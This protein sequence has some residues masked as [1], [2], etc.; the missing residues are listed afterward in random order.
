M[1]VDRE[2]MKSL[3]EA[4]SSDHGHFM[5]VFLSTSSKENWREV[6]TT[7]LNSAFTELMKN[8]SFS[9]EEKRHLE[10]DLARVREVLNY[11]IT[12]ETQGLAI[13]A[14]GSDSVFERVELPVVLEDRLAV[15]PS[16][17]LRPLLAALSALEPFVLVQVS[18]DD[19][20]I[21]VVDEGRVIK[22]D[23]FEG[24]YLKSSDPETGEV[25]I[26]EYY[27]AARQETLVDQ[28]HKEVAAAL[29][30]LLEQTRLRHVVVTGQH[31]IVNNFRRF[32]SQRAS[33][34]LL[35]EFALD[36]TASLNQLVAKAQ[37]VA[38]EGRRR[39]Q[40]DL[41]HR[42]KESL[43]S[44]GRGVAGFDDTAVALHRGQMEKLLV[45]AAYYPRGFRCIEC[46]FIS[47]TRSDDC[48]V[49]GGPM[50]SVEDAAGEAMRL[51]VLQGAFVE[52]A[53]EVPDLIDMGG[54]AGLLRYA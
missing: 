20:H 25:P 40:A 7:F 18:K 22:E 11:D 45:D 12:P 26:K 42:I 24:P 53:E 13:F 16:P 47:L 10:G 6:T 17:Y 33:S 14:D 41:A 44:G 36:A 54:I 19:S 4:R 1:R 46:D 39:L 49:C 5:S 30:H 28:H 3:A 35:G 38:R 48:P 15:G 50:E 37:E 34:R 8:R 27:A 32:L 23:D 2:K 43:G 21:Y 52:I 9:K 29:D 31:D 51:A